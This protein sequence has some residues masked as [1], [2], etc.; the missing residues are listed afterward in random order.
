[1]QYYESITQQNELKMK[2]KENSHFKFAIVEIKIASCL[3][4][5][6]NVSKHE[7]LHKQTVFFFFWQGK[8]L[9]NASGSG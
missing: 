9:N 4:G 5:K 2:T 3:L 6:Q 1:M 7:T 8:S